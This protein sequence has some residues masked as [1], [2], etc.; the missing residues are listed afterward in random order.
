MHRISEIHFYDITNTT[1]TAQELDKRVSSTTIPD[2]IR[3]ALAISL[4]DETLIAPNNASCPYWI[5]SGL[6]RKA[7]ADERFAQQYAPAPRNKTV[8]Q[9]LKDYTTKGRII[10]ARSELKKRMPFVS[11]SEQKKIL[12]AFF[13]NVSVDRQFALRFLDTNWDDFYIPYVE[14]AWRLFHEWQA[15]KVIVHHFPLDFIQANQEALTNDYSYLQMRLCLPADAPIDRT[16]L[17]D[18]AYLY[19]CARQSI[20]VSDTESEYIL[21]QNILNTIGTA[22]ISTSVLDLRTI[23]SIVW[24]LGVLGKT[25]ILLCFADFLKA[26]DPLVIAE[27]WEDVREMFRHLP[28]SLDFSTYDQ[29][30][31]ADAKRSSSIPSEIPFDLDAYIGEHTGAEMLLYDKPF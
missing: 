7:E 29:N 12:C 15:A 2:K 4:Q 6:R 23:S 28:M 24:S 26:L 31:A 27:E 19:L 13:E 14:R 9:L 10:K 8:E 30:I 11:F 17:A 1:M 5:Q 25:K 20:L 22:H 21:Y 3:Y 18:S 16:R